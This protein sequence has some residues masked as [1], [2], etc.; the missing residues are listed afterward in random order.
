[1]PY[2]DKGP[3]PGADRA[4]L[5]PDGADSLLIRRHRLRLAPGI[6]PVFSDPPR[7]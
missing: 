6:A 7:H 1:M 3:L 5:V 2:Q 4:C